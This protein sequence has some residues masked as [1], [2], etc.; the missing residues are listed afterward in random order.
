MTLTVVPSW[1]FDVSE[2]CG[3]V[4]SPCARIELYL[5]DCSARALAL[6]ARVGTRSSEWRASMCSL[7]KH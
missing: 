4:E 6:L 2:W 3:G 1:L 7:Q 5:Y